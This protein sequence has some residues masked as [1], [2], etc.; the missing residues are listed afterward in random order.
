MGDLKNG[1]VYNLLGWGTFLFVTASVVALFG[2]RLL[3]LPGLHLF[4]T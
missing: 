3:G 2:M 4:G 1:P